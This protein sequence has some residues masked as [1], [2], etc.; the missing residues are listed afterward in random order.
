MDMVDA[1]NSVSK[2]AIFQKLY[3]VGG[4]IIQHIPFE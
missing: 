2:G 1:F 4:D 3:I